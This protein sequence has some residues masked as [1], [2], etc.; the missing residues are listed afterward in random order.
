VTTGTVSHYIISLISVSCGLFLF[1]LTSLFITFLV[2]CLSF[3]I[4]R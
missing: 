3:L 1:S 4:L 2:H